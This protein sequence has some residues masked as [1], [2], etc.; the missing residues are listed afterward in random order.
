MSVS[1]QDILH[2]RASV[3]EAVEDLELLHKGN[4]KVKLTDVIHDLK[5]TDHKLSDVLKKLDGEHHH[6]PVHRT[7]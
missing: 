4:H 5:N 7:K 3:Q 2:I 1:K 6:T